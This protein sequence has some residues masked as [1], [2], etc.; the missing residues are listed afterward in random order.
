M[1]TLKIY[2][3]GEGFIT[4]YL[5]GSLYSDLKLQRCPL[6]TDRPLPGKGET[7][8]AIVEEVQ[9][10]LTFFENIKILAANCKGLPNCLELGGGSLW[11]EALKEILRMLNETETLNLVENWEKEI[12]SSLGFK[13][14]ETSV[15][16]ELFEF[17]IP[18]L[19]GKRDSYL[20]AW[21]Y[22]LAKKGTPSITVKYPHEGGYF[23]KFLA[24][25]VFS[26]K[27]VPLILGGVEK[28]VIEKVKK[29][30]FVPYRVLGKGRNSLE[31]ELNLVE[32][33]FKV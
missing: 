3:Q 27:L 1:K 4:Y 28:E 25:H 9:E 2:P 16:K 31:T 13:S 32:L 12:K 33:S 29:F 19:V 24:N 7:L 21:K 5:L 8:I 6:I 26:D 18:I 14:T 17:Y 15:R 23:Y 22:N 11:L 30:G 10:F 20:Y